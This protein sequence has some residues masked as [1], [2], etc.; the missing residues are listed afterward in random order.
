MGDDRQPHQ[1]RPVLRAGAPL[2]KARS[3]MI[4]VHGRGASAQSILTLAPELARP[5]FAYLAP[6][7]AD[8]TWYPFSFLAPMEQNEP[9]IS[10]G[11]QAIADV[12]ATIESAGI[13]A[14][15]TLLVGFSQGA[16]LALEFVARNARR[17]AGVAGLSGGL[18]GPDDT[19]RDYPGALAKTPVFLGCSDIDPHIPKERVVLTS[20]VMKRLGGAVTLRLY[21]GMGHT[22][23]VDEIMHVQAMMDAVGGEST[24]RAS[25]RAR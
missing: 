21:P 24:S 18:I 1:G 13:P 17:Y 3:A 12:L 23:N 2:E 10:S 22:V 6:D 4:L 25:P 15:R 20:E 8:G 14:E 5:T 9:G 11:I 7:A 19:P 16:C